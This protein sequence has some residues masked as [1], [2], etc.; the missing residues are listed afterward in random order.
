VHDKTGACGFLKPNTAI[1][2]KVP[3]P[4]SSPPPAEGFFTAVG[5]VAFDKGWACGT[6]A[7]VSYQGNTI[8]VNVVDQ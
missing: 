4:A 6:C 7:E 1:G 5:S 2:S 8:T 3:Y